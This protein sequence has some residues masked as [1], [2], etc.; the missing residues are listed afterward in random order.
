M[1]LGDKVLPPH[2]EETNSGHHSSALGE[3]SGLGPPA[4]LVSPAPAA[5]LHSLEAS[6]LPVEPL[7]LPRGTNVPQDQP[8]HTHPL[9]EHEA[10]GG[11]HEGDT[12]GG[13]CGR[14]LKKVMTL[15]KFSKVSVIY[16]LENRESWQ[17]SNQR[18]QERGEGGQSE[19]PSQERLCWLAVPGPINLPSLQFCSPPP[20]A[21]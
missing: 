13:N 14:E 5:Q 16:K 9:Q 19:A 2:T 7:I 3:R 1:E 6:Y 12:L 10:N 15:K 17:H 4:F 18:R 8:S 21:Y 11:T 20:L